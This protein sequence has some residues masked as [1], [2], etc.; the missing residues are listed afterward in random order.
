MNTQDVLIAASIQT[1]VPFIFCTGLLS[2][3]VICQ[4]C[5]RQTQCL[6]YV[7]ISSM[8]MTELQ[9]CCCYSCDSGTLHVCQGAIPTKGCFQKAAAACAAPSVGL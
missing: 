6:K 7:D 9:V 8:Q 2:D 3:T 5:A 4:P 1:A